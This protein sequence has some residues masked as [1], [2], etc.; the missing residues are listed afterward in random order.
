MSKRQ[1]DKGSPKEMQET[2]D[3]ALI[4]AN[5]LY[6][7]LVKT[8][9]A[10][11]YEASIG[12]QIASVTNNKNQRIY[13]TRSKLLEAVA[14][15]PDGLREAIEASI[16]AEEISYSLMNLIDSSANVMYQLQN[17][18]ILNGNPQSTF[19]SDS[20][21]H[22]PS[23]PQ[24]CPMSLPKYSDN[25]KKPNGDQGEYEKNKKKKIYLRYY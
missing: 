22:G 9:D 8:V 1:S 7:S 17:Y 18:L 13:D 24:F 6:N 23:P 3:E 15:D 10:L 25:T 16:K 4:N 2:V 14:T 11:Q 21:G 19:S 5:K 20:K 12:P